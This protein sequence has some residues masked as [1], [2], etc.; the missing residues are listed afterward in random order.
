MENKR[1]RVRIQYYTK[2]KSNLIA[3]YTDAAQAM[4]KF[5]M[6]AAQTF[7]SLVCDE[8]NIAKGTIHHALGNISDYAFDLNVALKGILSIK[9][10]SQVWFGRSSPDCITE[11]SERDYEYYRYLSENLL[12]NKISSRGLIIT[13]PSG[14]AKYFDGINEIRFSYEIIENGELSLPVWEE[15]F[16]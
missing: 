2:L 3:N 6:F 10:A 14:D 1:I 9:N 13:T 15:V 4:S 11:L 5:G 7:V 12:N 16:A 8:N